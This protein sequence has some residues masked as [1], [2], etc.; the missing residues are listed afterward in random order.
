MD[1]VWV[2]AGAMLHR[3]LQSRGRIVAQDKVDEFVRI[4]VAYLTAV[5]PEAEAVQQEREQLL[6]SHL[7]WGHLVAARFAAGGPDHRAMAGTSS[8]WRSREPVLV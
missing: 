5:H 6:L 7:F 3:S 1:D 2:H 4:V 8:Q